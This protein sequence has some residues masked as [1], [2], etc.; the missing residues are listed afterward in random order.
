M[1]YQTMLL[2]GRTAIERA[3][4]IRSTILFIKRARRTGCLLRQIPCNG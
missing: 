3:L 2:W 4:F 1:G